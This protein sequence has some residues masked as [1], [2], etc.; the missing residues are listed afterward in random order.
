MT[1]YQAFIPVI[2]PLAIAVLKVLLPRLPKVWLP[3]LAPILG[4][5]ADIALHQ[6]GLAHGPAWLG[7]TLGAAGVGLR[8]VADQVRKSLSA[9]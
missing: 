4:A 9:S 8:E 7:P 6:A 5:A 3:I 1:E 2:V